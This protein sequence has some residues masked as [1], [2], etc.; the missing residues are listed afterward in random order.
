MAGGRRVF[1][2]GLGGRERGQ[3]QISVKLPFNIKIGGHLHY[4]KNKVFVTKRFVTEELKL[5][6]SVDQIILMFINYL[7][8]DLLAG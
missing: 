3:I 1:D 8:T 2:T 4:L 5:P 7:P 6:S